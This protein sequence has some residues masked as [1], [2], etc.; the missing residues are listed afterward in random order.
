M[1]HSTWRDHSQATDYAREWHRR[2]PLYIA[3][4]EAIIASLQ[5][6]V[7]RFGEDFARTFKAPAGALVAETVQELG[8]EDLF[9]EFRTVVGN[10][11]GG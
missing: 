3:M 7:D 11:R 4:L 8:Y 6:P 10:T 9:A 1:E 5:E 2:L